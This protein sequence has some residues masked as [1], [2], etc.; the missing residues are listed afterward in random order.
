MTEM[1]TE[2]T[3]PRERWWTQPKKWAKG[4]YLIRW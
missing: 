4:T 1:A 2:M 3:S